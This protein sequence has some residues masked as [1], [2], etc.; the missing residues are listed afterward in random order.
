MSSVTAPAPATPHAFLF[1]ANFFGFW[2]GWREWGQVSPLREKLT[3]FKLLYYRPLVVT[4]ILSFVSD[5]PL[6]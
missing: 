5:I 2:N 1:G 6:G 4:L 3:E